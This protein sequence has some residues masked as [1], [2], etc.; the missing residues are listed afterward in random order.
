[1][2][3]E[4]TESP[5]EDIMLLWFKRYGITPD[6]QF[7]IPP[8]RVDFAFHDVKIVIECDG[9]EYHSKPLDKV[10]DEK[11]DEYLASKGWVVVR[12]TGEEIYRNPWQI[13]E[14]LIAIGCTVDEKERATTL[15]IAENDEHREVCLMAALDEFNDVS[16]FLRDYTK[17]QKTKS[18]VKKELRIQQE[19]IQILLRKAESSFDSV[20]QE[21]KEIWSSERLQWANVNMK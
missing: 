16:L 20:I 2:N 1:M 13:V 4:K 11:R 7:K 17:D 6:V 10:F 15:I 14:N 21:K 18:D 5:I 3:H 9:K 8:Y 12:V 19:R